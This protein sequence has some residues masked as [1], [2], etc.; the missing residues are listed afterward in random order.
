MDNSKKKVIVLDFDGTLTTN[1]LSHL[2]TLFQLSIKSLSS[3]TITKIKRFYF[4]HQNDNNAMHSFVLGVLGKLFEVRRISDKDLDKVAYSQKLMDNVNL[5]FRF[6]KSKGYEIHIISGG[7]TKVIEKALGD[8]LKY[9]D[10]LIA[11]DVRFNKNGIV[12]NLYYNYQDNFGKKRYIESLV[13]RGF[14]LDNVCF[15]GNS[16]NDLSVA[17]LS[18]SSVFVNPDDFVKS[19]F[20][21]YPYP[22]TIENEND[23]MK[24]A[25]RADDMITAKNYI[26]ENCDDFDY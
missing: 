5:A 19:K 7:I 12:K 9:A 14:S 15:V 17:G 2:E 3:E 11:N 25:K 20:K 24:V 22:P 18:C 10:V 8:N 6:L 16:K 21:D 23:F 1:K 26:K 13:N 4:K